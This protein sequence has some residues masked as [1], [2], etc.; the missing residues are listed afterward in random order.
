MPPATEA[1]PPATEALPP[2]EPRRADAPRRT[3][4]KPPWQ[5][6]GFVVRR[7]EAIA[8]AAVLVVVLVIVII[9]AS[10]GDGS[11]PGATATTT[12]QP[13]PAGAPVDQQL[14]QLEKIVRAAPKQ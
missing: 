6:G 5:R 7:V 9:A 2:T 14:D 3:D 8:A 4:A 10:S 13:A 1:L 12:V 11:K